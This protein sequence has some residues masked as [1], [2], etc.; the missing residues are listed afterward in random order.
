MYKE[1]TLTDTEQQRA[2]KDDSEDSSDMF[3]GPSAERDFVR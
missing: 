1:D 3:I 2:D